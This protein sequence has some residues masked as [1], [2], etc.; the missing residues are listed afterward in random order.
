MPSG[1]VMLVPTCGGGTALNL[2]HGQAVLSR[3][4]ALEGVRVRV[5]YPWNACLIFE[6]VRPLEGFSLLYVRCRRGTVLNTWLLSPRMRNLVQEP[7]RQ[8]WRCESRTRCG[9]RVTCVKEQPD[10]PTFDPVESSILNL[11]GI[12]LRYTGKFT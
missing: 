5:Y 10:M 8:N 7:P 1:F 6:E 9:W 2:S 3:L 4:Q 12:C 11:G